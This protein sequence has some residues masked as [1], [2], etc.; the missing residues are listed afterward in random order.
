[1]RG[2]RSASGHHQRHDNFRVFPY[3]YVGLELQ[4]LALILNILSW[5]SSMLF[6]TAVPTAYQ[7]MRTIFCSYVI[8][9]V[10]LS[11]TTC[12]RFKSWVPAQECVWISPVTGCVCTGGPTRICVATYVAPRWKYPDGQSGRQQLWWTEPVCLPPIWHT[13][14]IIVITDTNS[15]ARLFLQPCFKIIGN[16][17]QGWGR[18]LPVSAYGYH[19]TVTMVIRQVVFFPWLMGEGYCQCPIFFAMCCL[20]WTLTGAA[21]C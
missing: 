7:N 5:I 1:M 4:F 16:F 10:G 6:I 14:C 19:M 11:R 21:L 17:P 9:F 15:T 2:D 3:I 18:W 20:A 12:A 13:L 8:L